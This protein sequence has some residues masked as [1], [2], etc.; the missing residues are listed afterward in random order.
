M[1][2]PGVQR[3]YQARTAKIRFNQQSCFER[4]NQLVVLF[5]HVRGFFLTIQSVNMDSIPSR[6]LYYTPESSR[7]VVLYANLDRDISKGI[8]L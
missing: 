8:T 7:D 4:I 1:R 5:T 6:S 2:A 3:V